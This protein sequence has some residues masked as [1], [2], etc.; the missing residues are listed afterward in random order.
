MINL[1]LR[2]YGLLL[3]CILLINNVVIASRDDSSSDQFAIVPYHGDTESV[4]ESDDDELSFSRAPLFLG[5]SRIGRLFETIYPIYSVGE[6]GDAQ[7]YSNPRD[8]SS[9]SASHWLDLPEIYR[10]SISYF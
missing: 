7:A 6:V 2:R 9:N 4:S 1:S 3:S 5:S 10:I 8:E